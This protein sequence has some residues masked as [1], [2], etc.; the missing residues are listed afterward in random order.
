MERRMGMRVGKR[1]KMGR[2]TRKLYSRL[3]SDWPKRQNGKKIPSGEETGIR[4]R[5]KE[6]AR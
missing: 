3:Q 6:R 5:K 4:L 1:K 2:R